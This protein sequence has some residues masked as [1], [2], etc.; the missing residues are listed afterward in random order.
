MRLFVL[1]ASA[2]IRLFLR[3]G[4]VVAGL[5]AAAR[6]VE[7]GAA[8]FVA[9]EMILVEAANALARKVRRRH[10]RDAERRVLWQEMRRVPID[11]LPVAGFVEPAMDLAVQRDLTVHDALYLAV[12]MHA[13]AVL[14]SADDALAAAARAEGLTSADRP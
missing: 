7:T 12:A 2:W 8:A 4:P 5:E 13:G 10:L 6:E 3:D 1:D 14:F 9:P 11:L